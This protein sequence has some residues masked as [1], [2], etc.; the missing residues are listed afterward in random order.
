[1]KYIY[2]CCPNSDSNCER[3]MYYGG[4]SHGKVRCLAEK[5]VYRKETKRR[6]KNGS[7]NQQR[8]S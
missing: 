1:M 4:F 8:N 6:K 2:D 7:K 5:S 3:C